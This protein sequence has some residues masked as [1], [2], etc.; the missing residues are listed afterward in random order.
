M[1]SLISVDLP[2]PFSASSVDLT[3]LNDQPYIFK[4]RTP[5]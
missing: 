2:A 1:I 5:P 3:A 4:R